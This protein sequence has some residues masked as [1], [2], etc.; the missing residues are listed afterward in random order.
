MA[1][2]FDYV[3]VGSGFGGG[4]AALRLAQAGKRVC[5]LER[6]RRWHGKNLPPAPGEKPASAFP[7]LG[8]TSFFWGRQ[9]W[10]PT[11]QRLGLYE[12][13]QM[14]NLQGL[15]GAGVGGGSLIWAN[16]VVKAPDWVFEKNW[17]KDINR[18]TLDSYYHRADPYLRPK[19]IPGIATQINSGDG[20][21]N[22][23]AEALR[24][25]AE[26]VGRPWRP[27]PLAVNFGDQTNA[28]PNGHGNAR[29]LGC[30][31]CGLC[32]AGCPQGAKN[33]VDKTYIAEAEALGAE[34]WP[35]HLATGIEPTEGGYRV[36]FKRFNLDGTVA[37][38]GCVEAKRVVLS[39]GTFG[40]TELLLNCRKNGLLP[41]LSK[42]LGTRF[43][44]NGN[45]LGGALA[46]GKANAPV[47]T[48]S[49]PAIASM[50]D[51]GRFAIEDI[52]NPT[53][54]AGIVGE[55][56]IKRIIAFT[57]AL[58]GYKQTAKVSA[59]AARDLLLYVGVGDDGARGRLVLNKLGLLGLKWPGGISREP[60]IQALH[61]AMAELAK[62][63][64]RR[65]VPNAMSIFNRPV[66]YHPLGG[67]PMADTVETGVV[68][69]YGRVF[70]YP[71]L[72]IADGSV[73]PTALGSNPSYTI[74]ALAE[75]IAERLAKELD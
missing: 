15:V 17:P 14:I 16:V 43:S 59:Q 13:K 45:V 36:H 61:K 39:A 70:G 3:V 22:H 48:N 54:T 42:A 68:D 41:N 52:A 37:E 12:M 35:L 51:Y 1:D 31:L 7:E 75:R 64:G 32:T 40:S 27:V 30:N 34:V 65:Y 33:T 25:S 18:R 53:W 11:R 71:G 57:L 23:R 9:L 19:L 8:D 46:V 66:T 28:Q 74:A 26:K 29:Q 2:K 63:Q 62:A 6:G 50:I 5:V 56:N 67:C 72:F 20:K 69:S 58:T 21:Y 24:L 44:I 49:G 60:G 10:R 4:T 55:T 38:T 47:N 73:V